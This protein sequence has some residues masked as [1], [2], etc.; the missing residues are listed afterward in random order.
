MAYLYEDKELVYVKQ[1]KA[2]KKRVILVNL[3]IFLTNVFATLILIFNQLE[4]WSYLQLI[5]PVF[6]LNL[7][8]SYAM[9]INRDS[10]QQ[11]Y[12][13]M[14]ISIIG[15]IVVVLNIFLISKTPATYMLLYLAIALISIYND[16]KAVALGY[17]I[18]FVFGTI[19]HF[20]HTNVIIGYNSGHGELTALMYE[21]LLALTILV[22]VGRM[23][24]NEA[25]I[26]QLY[27]DLDHQKEMELKYHTTIY[28]LL[29]KQNVIA[30][31]NDEYIKE[32]TKE[33]LSKYLDLF[34]QNFYLVNDINEKL[35]QYLLLQ[36]EKDTR[37]VIGRRLLGYQLRK[38]MDQFEAMST[39]KPS[40]F[41]SLVL[42]LKYK[43]ID[44]HKI[45]AFKNYNLMFIDPEMDFEVRILG[46]VLLYDHLRMDHQYG[47]GLS[48]EE[49]LE[50]LN[51]HE[52]KEM[53]DKEIVE[54]FFEHEE[55]F[56]AI[57]EEEDL[58]DEE[59]NLKTG[60][61]DETFDDK[62]L[63]DTTQE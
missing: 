48:H 25:E 55:T 2:L 46:F 54:F 44:M 4:T 6:V 42:S 32:E 50:L 61:Q 26:D 63:L 35:D 60:D 5:I 36:Q 19:I 37:K 12:L 59:V 27:D 3:I 11:L 43:Q 28:D 22:Q 9:V 7:V 24:F 1:M 33:R 21:T 40:K 10:Y 31:F 51:T 52:A 13:A 14:Y 38:E 15:I 56:R 49:V 18:I 47:R 41:L 8:I 20:K 17:G 23:Y 45:E 57:Y 39:Y 53:F 16:K 30:T 62:P 58:D 29:E 34:N